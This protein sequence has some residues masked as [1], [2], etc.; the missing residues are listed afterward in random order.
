MS[1]TKQLKT[2]N[3]AAKRA[4][5]TASYAVTQEAFD[6]AFNAGMAYA[7]AY[8]AAAAALQPLL[9]PLS[10]SEAEHAVAQWKELQRGFVLGMAEAREIDPDS[11]RKAFN[12]LVE[13]LGL[14]KP[15]TA[16]AKAKQAERAKKKPAKAAEEDGTPVDGAG[17]AAAQAVK[18]ELSRMEAHLISLV[19][20]GKFEMAAEC[21]ASMA[22][23]E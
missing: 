21:V 8:H 19:R 3:K 5:K 6:V 20:A 10:G 13:Y 14:E 4:G 16:E 23:A 11:A 22:E 15:Q 2:G 17:D 9:T 12:R 18:M 7:G 1:T